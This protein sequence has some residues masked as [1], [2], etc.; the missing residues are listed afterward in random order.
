[1]ERRTKRAQVLALIVVGTVYV[2]AGKIGLHFAFLNASASPIWP[3]TGIALTAMLLLG[4]RI[5]PAV[6]VGA[7]LVNVT[8]AGSIA[9]SLGIALGNTLE[10]VLGASLVRRFAGGRL[11]FARA[12]DI[13]TFVGLAGLVSTTVSATIGVTSLALGGHARWEDY[14]SVWLTWWLGDVAGNLVVAPLLLIWIEDHDLSRLRAR[15][16]E[17]ALLA[18]CALIVSFAV[19]GGALPLGTRRYPVA[20]VCIPPLLWAAF[21]FGQREASTLMVLMAGLAMAG[22]LRGVG[23]FARGSVNESLLLVQAFMATMTLTILPVAALVWERR[24]ADQAARLRQDQLRVA[25]DAA[26]M[27]TWEWTI[28]T[29]RV[30]WSPSLE[31]MHGLAPGA[32]GGT[33]EA[34]QADVHPDDREA[35]AAAI[36]DALARG[37]HH[38]EYRIVRPDGETRWVEGRGE[39]FRNAAGRPERMLGVCIDVTE[40]TRL[41]EREQAARAEAETANRAKDE[42]LAMLGHELRNPLGAI[43]NAV[44]VLMRVES[45]ERHGVAAREVIDR[46]VRR[47][48]R[49]VDDLLDVSRAMSGKIVL[50]RQTLD[51]ADVVRRVLAT[52]A[53][54]TQGYA[55]LVEIQSV[56]VAGDVVRLE[57]LITNLLENALKYTPRGGEIQ[58]SVRQ[59]GGTAVFSVR[60]TGVGIPADLIHRIF[61][62]FVQGDHS[63]D[64]TEGGLGIGLTLVR[65]IAELHSGSV[66]AASEGIGR[67]SRFTVRLPAATP[68]RESGGAAAAAP[69]RTGRRVLVVEDNDDSRQMLVHLI[70]LLGHEVYE[71]ADGLSAVDAVLRLE[72]DIAL[73]DVGLP[74]LDGYEVAR[75]I[76]RASGQYVH[77]VAL[78]GYGRPEDRERALAAG[79]D[80]HLVK[81]VDPVRLASVLAAPVC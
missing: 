37:T 17:A 44:H 49:L 66:E 35:V 14:G 4:P 62:L 22:T 71:A 32:F 78:T 3:P 59:E 15:A 34:F 65:R 73:V 2:L 42:F 23:P 64:R 76:R 50:E 55:L 81:P 20:F 60:D 12:R 63:L 33:F 41:L 26:R 69:V 57:Q 72:P 47:L 61:D 46:Q 10:A 58:A 25:L 16:L 21:R 53:D 77:L 29:G 68:P 27:G 70:R 74:A 8:T 30:T 51:L 13:F 31:T 45:Q 56:W 1:M 19:F 18:A 40:R 24:H 67:G 52:F 36:G 48:S 7:F 28:A 43:S 75:R 6:F 79:Y 9:T 38:I 5:W 39:M 80:A 54:R 11:A